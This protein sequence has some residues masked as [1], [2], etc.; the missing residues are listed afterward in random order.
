MSLEKRAEKTGIKEHICIAPIDIAGDEIKCVYCHARIRKFESEH[1]EGQHYKTA[2]CPEC[3]KK[4]WVKVSFEGSGHDDFE[5][6]L[7]KG[8]KEIKDLRLGGHAQPRHHVRRRE[9]EKSD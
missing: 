8:V 1:A 9:E 7:E 6:E 4:I 2:K 5:S 3:G